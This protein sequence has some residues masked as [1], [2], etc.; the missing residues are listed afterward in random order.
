MQS[1]FFYGDKSEGMNCLRLGLNT[2]KTD[3]NQS[4][5]IICAD[6]HHSILAVKYKSK[7]WPKPKIT[8]Y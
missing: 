8:Y 3:R 4:Y 2:Y 6:S 7:T 5:Y 1:H